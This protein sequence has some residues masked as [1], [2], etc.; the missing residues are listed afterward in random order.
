[1]GT[2]LFDRFLAVA[3]D[4]KA[5]NPSAS[6]LDSGVQQVSTCGVQLGV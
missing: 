5:Q 1:M 4:P 2:V 6:G 3:V